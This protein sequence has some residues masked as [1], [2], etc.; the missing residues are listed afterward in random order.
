M[1]FEKD[2]A[3]AESYL[4]DLKNCLSALS[5]NEKGSAVRII[6]NL[7]KRIERYRRY[8]RPA[9]EWKLKVAFHTECAEQVE[10][11]SHEILNNH[12]DKCAP[13]GEVFCCSV[14]MATEAVE[15]VLGRL[16]LLLS[17]RKETHGN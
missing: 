15:T 7:G 5:G 17:V 9:G 14:S 2:V 11:L 1:P 3:L 13:F 12:L 8:D 6:K 16:G 4:A 10:L